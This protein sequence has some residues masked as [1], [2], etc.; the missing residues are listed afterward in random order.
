[1]CGAAWMGLCSEGGRRPEETR[2]SAA[3][4]GSKTHRGAYP[5]AP[6]WMPP[7]SSTPERRDEWEGLPGL[8]SKLDP[9]LGA[10]AASRQALELGVFSEGLLVDMGTNRKVA[11]VDNHCGVVDARDTRGKVCRAL[12]LGLLKGMSFGS[13]P[14]MSQWNSPESLQ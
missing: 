6:V 5:P 4:R 13:E 1:M 9:H 2:Q 3:K 12:E 8:L 11:L 14:Q 7:R 10:R